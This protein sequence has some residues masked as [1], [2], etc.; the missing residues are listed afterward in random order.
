[1]L[2]FPQI[3]C[4][5]GLPQAASPHAGHTNFERVVLALLPLR[6]G[7]GNSMSN[8]DPDAEGGWDSSGACVPFGG[9]TIRGTPSSDVSA[10]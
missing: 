9:R 5:P 6:V 8:P 3:K 10:K 7:E 2:H 1:M 4:K